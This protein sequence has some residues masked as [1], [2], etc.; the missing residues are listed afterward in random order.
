MTSPR[1]EMDF[2]GPSPIP[3]QS[4]SCCSSS[5]DHGQRHRCR[6]RRHQTGFNRE[7]D[8]CRA[9]AALRG[10]R[11]PVGR[12]GSRLGNDGGSD[13]D[14]E[15][16]NS[17]RMSLVS[18]SSSTSS[19][20][21]VR[22]PSGCSHNEGSRSTTR[23]SSNPL[24]GSDSAN[25]A[26]SDDSERRQGATKTKQ[27][28][29]PAQPPRVVH[30]LSASGNKESPSVVNTLGLDCPTSVVPPHIASGLSRGQ[31]PSGRYGWAGKTLSQM[32]AGKIEFREGT[33]AL[34]LE[35]RQPAPPVRS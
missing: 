31:F 26:C 22:S 12:R 4:D 32:K 21:S 29:E 19:S 34:T 9:G 27:R 25:T 6:G 24:A 14:G 15:S 17:F 3:T 7:K 1:V 11:F 23:S 35:G 8:E 2:G 33:R 18:S 28:Q 20:S 5:H 30:F 10:V 16:R 13:E